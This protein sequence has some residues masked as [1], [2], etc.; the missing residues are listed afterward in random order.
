MFPLAKVLNVVNG[1]S[2]GRSVALVLKGNNDNY[3]CILYGLFFLLYIEEESYM[4]AN[5]GVL[6]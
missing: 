5:L 2:V 3:E 4:R 1:F 6:V